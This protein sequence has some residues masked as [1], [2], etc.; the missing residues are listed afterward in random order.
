MKRDL[1]KISA[2]PGQTCPHRNGMQRCSVGH[3]CMLGRNAADMRTETNVSVII[4]LEV[5]RV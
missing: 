2:D 5:A 1:W 4:I 3:R